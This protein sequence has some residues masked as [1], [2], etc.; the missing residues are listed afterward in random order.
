MTSIA[1]IGAGSIDPQRLYTFKEFQPT[2]NI[3]YPTLW[4][5]RK[6]GRAPEP[7]VKL[8]RKN[9]WLGQDILDFVQGKYQP[10]PSN[11]NQT[12]TK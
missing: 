7:R 8:S 4:R 2:V 11:L 9:L 5:M 12:Q 10:N 6:D 1:T 3:S